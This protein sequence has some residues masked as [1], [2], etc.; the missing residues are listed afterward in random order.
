MGAVYQGKR[1]RTGAVIVAKWSNLGSHEPISYG[2]FR[3]Q[4]CSV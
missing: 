2:A 3:N 1:R 4:E